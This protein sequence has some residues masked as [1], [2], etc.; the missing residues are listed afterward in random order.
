MVFFAPSVNAMIAN[1][2]CA[3]KIIEGET[4]SGYSE[5]G[6]WILSMH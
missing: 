4:L 1:K 2:K 5:S 6:L 3:K